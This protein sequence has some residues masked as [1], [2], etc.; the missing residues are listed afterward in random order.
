MLNEK[1]AV[2]GVSGGVDS[3]VAAQLLRREGYTVLGVYLRSDRFRDESAAAEEAAAA[4][5]IE[6][7]VA[8]I[9]EPLDRCV[10]KPFAESYLRG[11]TPNPCVWCNR[12][13]K[14]PALAAAA[15]AFG[16]E[17]VATGHYARIV[18]PNVPGAPCRMVAAAPCAN[19]QSYMLYRVPDEL[20]ARLRFPLA[21][22][23]KEQVRAA[24]AEMCLASKEKPDSMEVCFIP[25]NDRIAW[26]EREAGADRIADMAGCFVD[27]TGRVLGQHGGIHRYTVGQRRG[28]AVAAGRRIY[29][30]A[31]DPAAKT[32]TLGENLDVMRTSARITDC[33]WHLR[34]A[35]DQKL[36]IRVRHSR[37]FADGFAAADDSGDAVLTFPDGVRAP[38]PGQS[39]V[40][41]AEMNGELVVVGGGFL[42][43]ER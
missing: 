23:N 10:V 38:A 6:F 43:T 41:Y 28:L 9:T 8:D 36:K 12:A 30:T 3:A 42:A 1:R 32:V 27:E 11:E 13:V 29:V 20:I 31:I 18:T 14:F 22:L 37:T 21:G 39:A 34:P 7:R 5:G 2:L 15:D 35:P 16:A 26:L 24:A 25:D 40:C 17:I 4:A 33:V 19:D